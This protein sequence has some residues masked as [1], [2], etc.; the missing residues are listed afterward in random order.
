MNNVRPSDEQV[1][2]KRGQGENHLAL[3]E[4]RDALREEVVQARKGLEEMQGKHNEELETLRGQ[5][6]TSQGEKEQAETQYRGLLGKVSTIR[7]QLGERLKA[8]AV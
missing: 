4:E 2:I 6:A 8:D 1:D 7:S 5:L 3:L